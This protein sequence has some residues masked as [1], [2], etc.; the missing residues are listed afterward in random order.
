M[1]LRHL[2]VR[3]VK[4]L[5]DVEVDFVGADDRPRMWTV[6]VGE[7]RLCKTTL[8]QTIAAAACG[9]DRG[10]QLVTDVVASW[11]DLRNPVPLAIEAEFG[12]SESRHERRRYPTWSRSGPIPGGTTPE[13]R[14]WSRLE[15]EPGNRVFGG[16]S[17]YVGDEASYP[18]P[19]PTARRLALRDWFVA[20]YGPSRLLQGAGKIARQSEPTIDRLR[21]LFGESLIGTGFIEL[22]GEELSRSFIKVLE[23]IFVAGELL[24]HVTALELKGRGGI[25]SGRDLE[26]AQR[27]EMDLLDVHGKRIRVPA[28][29]L[30]QGYQSLIAWLADLVGQ[31]LLDAGEPVEAA[32]MEGTVLVDEIDVHL[33]PTWQVRLIP[34]LKKVF[35]RLQFIATTHSPMVL[36]ALAAEEVYLLSQD[37]EGNV[38]ARPSAK[39]PALLTG[40]ELYDAFFEIRKLYPEALGDKLHRYG[41]LA[42]DPTRSAEEDATMRAL[43]HELEAAGV[44]FDW[45]PVEREAAE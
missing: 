41:N 5:R 14:L 39:S 24:P 21:P 38:T 2:Q 8:L 42:T 3:N 27:F 12:F 16:G 32:D 9:Q 18:D 20:G 19:L 26:D 4:L 45:A 43:K 44:A 6:F 25:R 36:P 15:L 35:P 10:T 13:R 34:A 30:S 23:A 37:A 40:S 1:Y 22:L 33:H 17:G 7:N 11:P 28:T 29:W 31:I